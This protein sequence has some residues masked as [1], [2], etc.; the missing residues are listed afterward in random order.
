MK[1]LKTVQQCDA[2]Y[3]KRILRYLLLFASLTIIYDDMRVKPCSLHVIRMS[4]EIA[5]NTSHFKGMH[6]THYF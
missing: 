2:S 1:V 4:G 3:V 6:E 5:W